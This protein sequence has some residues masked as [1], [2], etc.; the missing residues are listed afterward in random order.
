MS[1][2][3]QPMMQEQK[4][5]TPAPRTDALLTKLLHGEGLPQDAAF[6]AL[7]DHAYELERELQAMT[8]YAELASDVIKRA[9]VMGERP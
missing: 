6:K 8:D 7:Q 1:E 2:K 9:K 3:R 5:A 4:K